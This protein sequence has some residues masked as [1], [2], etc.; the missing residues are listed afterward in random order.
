MSLIRTIFQIDNKGR[1][2]LYNSRRQVL[3]GGLIFPVGFALI[4]IGELATG[5]YVRW[6]E[7]LLIL[8]NPLALFGWWLVGQSV[9]AEREWPKFEKKARKK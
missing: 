2:P 9:F 4:L 7:A 8:F 3:I 1:M 6:W 5:T